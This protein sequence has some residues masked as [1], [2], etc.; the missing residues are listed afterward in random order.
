MLCELGPDREQFGGEDGLTM[1]M[2]VVMMEITFSNQNNIEIEY[3]GLINERES[4]KL[5]IQHS[6]LKKY[7]SLKSRL[8]EK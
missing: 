4:D 3:Q 5:I 7:N 8:I 2:V 6:N 1:M